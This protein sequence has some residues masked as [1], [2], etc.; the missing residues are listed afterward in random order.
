MGPSPSLSGPGLGSVIA[1]TYTLERSLGRGGMGSVFLASHARL[2]GKQVAIKILHAELT[3]PEVIARFKR[4]AE[5]ASQLGHPNIV[6]VDDYNVTPEGVPYLVL[7]LLRGHTLAER[8][9]AGP[10]SLDMACSILRQVGSALGAAHRA[11]IVHRDLKPQNIMLI[12]SEVEGHAADVA[13]VLDFGISKILGSETVKTHQSALLGTPQYMAP[14]Q[15]LSQHTAVDE[16]TDEFALG[17]IAYEMLC[18]SPPFTGASIPEVVFQV[19]YQAAPPL[20]ARAPHVPPGMVA[21]VERAM[22]KDQAQRFPTV[23]A[24]IEALTGA[25]LPIV[26][27]SRAAVAAVGLAATVDSQSHASTPSRPP[28]RSTPPVSPVAAT[29]ASG[30]HPPLVVPSAAVPARGRSRVPAVIAVMTALGALAGGAMFV[31]ARSNGASPP[32]AVAR[33]AVTDPAAVVRDAPPAT[34]WDARIDAVDV[35]ALVTATATTPATATATTTTSPPAHRP[36]RQSTKPVVEHSVDPVDSDAADAADTA[37]YVSK[38]MALATAALAA[39]R[40]QD[41]R[42]EARTVLSADDLRRR[43]RV[44]ASAVEAKA[45]CQLADTSSFGTAQRRLARLK[46]TAALAD[47]A[48]Y[49]AGHAS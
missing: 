43:W 10:L 39:R 16:R 1:G 21:A 14:E 32:T 5:I 9:A 49:C 30:D 23:S 36:A 34:P 24:F 47:V 20:G 7:E 15:A 22:A 3:T 13:K 31:L 29:L 12:A 6:G 28:A 40:W 11:G 44:Q 2:P 42:K 45:S 18:G 46:A 19:A 38:H 17:V 48:R 35:A 25:P 26:S 37:A 41:A 8:I 27:R 4:E 33:A